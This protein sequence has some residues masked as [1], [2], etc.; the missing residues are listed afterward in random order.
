MVNTSAVESAFVVVNARSG[1]RPSLETIAARLG[2]CLV[3]SDAALPAAIEQYRRLATTLHYAQEQRGLR[4]LMVASA[5]P[6]EGKTLTTANLAMTLSESYR[7]RVL[8]IDADLRRPSMHDVF[9]L[10]NRAGLNDLLAALP[11][12]D[13]PPAFQVS[14]RLTVLTAGR[15]TSDPM[16][17]LTSVA[18]RKLLGSAATAYDWVIIDTPPVALLSDANL[19]TS[20]TDGVILVVSAGTVSY[21]LIQRAVD[22]LGRNRII[23]VVLNRATDA[24]LAAHYGYGGYYGAYRPQS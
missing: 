16:S 10:P 15:P 20:G 22:A 9:G 1:E 17:A 23:G 5:M 2:G 4:T 6:S 19:L 11:D 18:L 21:K 13:P 14:D 8:V 3:L 24:L 12:A 7:R